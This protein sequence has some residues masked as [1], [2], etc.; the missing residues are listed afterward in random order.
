M[1]AYGL[2][3]GLFARSLVPPLP[4]LNCSFGRLK[5]DALTIYISFFFAH[6]KT[7]CVTRVLITH[8]TQRV[9]QKY[10]SDGKTN[11]QLQKKEHN[12][13]NIF[14]TQSCLYTYPTM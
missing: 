8:V 14:Y 6:T 4:P 13:K 1:G 5:S 11:I 7:L 9:Q 2:I 10:R 12:L 3:R